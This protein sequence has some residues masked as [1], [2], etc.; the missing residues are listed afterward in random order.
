[1]FSQIYLVFRCPRRSVLLKQLTKLAVM[2]FPLYVLKGLQM[3]TGQKLGLASVFCLAILVVIFDIL[4][5]VF[6][7]KSARGGA[8][9]ASTALSDILEITIAVIV[10]C[11]PTYRTI[12]TQKQKKKQRKTNGT[13]SNITGQEQHLVK[14]Q[15]SLELAN[16]ESATNIDE[17]RIKRILAGHNVDTLSTHA[18]AFADETGLQPPEPALIGFRQEY[19]VT[20]Q[21]K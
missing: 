4:R 2:A 12:L 6:S 16:V 18:V 7:A 15:P 9:R 5:T 8:V 10:S 11:L 1:M 3:Q 21:T 14:T 17:T 20:G 13:Y 19:S